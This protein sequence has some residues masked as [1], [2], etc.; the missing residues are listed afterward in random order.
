MGSEDFRATLSEKRLSIGTSGRFSSFST[1]QQIKSIAWRRCWPLVCGQPWRY[2]QISA[3]SYD[4]QAYAKQVFGTE[5]RKHPG[6]AHVF[7]L[8]DVLLGGTVTVGAFFEPAKT[9]AIPSIVG[10]RE[11]VAANAISS[12][13]WCVAHARQPS[14]A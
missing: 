8:G 5:D 9:A 12:V 11:L 4:R 14:A 7:D 2:C 1:C 3:Y 6:V 10:D 13:T